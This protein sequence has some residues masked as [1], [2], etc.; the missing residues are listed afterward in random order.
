METKTIKSVS[1]QN[2]EFCSILTAFGISE[3]ENKALEILKEYEQKREVRI[4]QKGKLVT[5]ENWG[6]KI[7]SCLDDSDDES[8]E[9]C[10]VDED[11]ANKTDEEEGEIDIMDLVCSDS[12]DSMS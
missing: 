6:K 10:D 2:I 5:E 12:E 4:Y 7:F 3:D 8:E 9:F 1:G 11:C